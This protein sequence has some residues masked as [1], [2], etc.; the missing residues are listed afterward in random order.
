MATG[1]YRSRNRPRGTIE[2]ELP[3]ATAKQR[4]LEE[5]REHP[6]AALGVALGLGFVAG[7]GPGS[8]ASARVVAAGMR[9]AV[10]VLLAPVAAALVELASR[11]RSSGRSSTHSKEKRT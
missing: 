6:Y 11:L 10:P 3:E 1:R 4:L 7:R 9:A 8:R 2:P 5:L